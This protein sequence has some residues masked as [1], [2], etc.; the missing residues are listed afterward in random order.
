MIFE[1]KLQFFLQNRTFLH[2]HKLQFDD[3]T[4]QII[5]D[6]CIFLILQLILSMFIL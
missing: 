5:H 2:F 6:I 3:S 4:R 1:K